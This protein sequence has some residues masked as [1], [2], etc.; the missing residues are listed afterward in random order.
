MKLYEKDN[1]IILEEI[2]NFDAKAI[3]TCG[4]AFR[5]YEESDGSFTTVHL[6]RV[7]NVLNEKDRV[8]F[9]GTNLKEFD[10]IWMDYFDLNTDYKEIRKVLSNNEILPKAME[11]GE[12]IRILNQNHFEMLISFII[13]ANNMI[14]RIKKSI[15][16]ISMRYGKFICEDENRKYYSF[17]TV[18]EL[19]KATVEDLR[20]FA[21]V[22][23]RDKRIFDTVNMIL[24]EKIDLDNFENLETDV[25]REELLKFAGV[26]NK[27]ADC[28]MLFSYKRGEVFPVDVWIKRV[29][30]E[31]FIKEET[32]VKKISKEADRIF[33]KY[34][35]YAQQYLFY[36][37]REEKIGK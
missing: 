15:E 26:G 37:G 16:V 18:E 6:G 1:S 35:G 19:S 28:I 23:F 31:L 22:G 32:P 14:P 11:Y 17:P 34:A 21:K 2:E 5:W 30:E 9:K 29:M 12:G 7:L 33:G 20:E 10:E 8:I 4:Q 27:V 24:N 13:S 36:Y 25:L 3:F